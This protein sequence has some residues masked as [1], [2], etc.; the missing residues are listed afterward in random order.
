MFDWAT[1]KDHADTILSVLGV[2]ASIGVVL[3]WYVKSGRPFLMRLLGTWDAIDRIETGQRAISA[4]LSFNGGSTLK[5]MVAKHGT[6]LDALSVEVALVR[7]VQRT[8]MSQTNAAFYETDAQGR[9]VWVNRFYLEMT[10]KMLADVLVNGWGTC[11]APQ[12]RAAVLTE[13]K[14]CVETDRDFDAKFSMLD[15]S[16]APFKVRSIA[17]RVKNLSGITMAFAGS[18]EVLGQ[19]SRVDLHALADA[20]PP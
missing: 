1:V 12:D 4:E 10:G 20:P 5:D 18:L 19:P 8:M 17:R 3:T 9:C 15:A 16:G 6:R 7:G 13:W 14:D 11:I 2:L